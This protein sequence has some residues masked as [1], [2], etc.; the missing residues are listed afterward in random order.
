MERRQFK[1][2]DTR[3]TIIEYAK[4]LEEKIIAREEGKFNPAVVKEV[5]RKKEV[6]EKSEKILKREILSQEILDEH[7]AL[8]EKIEDMKNEI[9][10][11]ADIDINVNTL[12]ALIEANN[13]EVAQAQAAKEEIIAEKTAELAA[14]EEEI[15]TK[16]AEWEEED[17]Q[18]KADLQV[19]RDRE[20]ADHKYILDRDRKKENDEWEDTKNAREKAIDLRELAVLERE[21]NCNAIEETNEALQN[22][23]ALTASKIAEIEKTA[24]ED[25]EKAANKTLAIREAAMKKEVE[26]DK[27]MVDAELINTKG[28]LAKAEAALAAKDAELKEA[29]AKMN[30]LATKSVQAGQTVYVNKDNK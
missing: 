14:L 21:V 8:E 6:K 18:Y 20:A 1:T 23:L 27:K 15:K 7:K 12:A 2:K 25:A 26:F 28:A 22:E 9:K 17:K 11:I 29:Y 5:E 4:E 19:K 13:I 3:A 16:K 24:K 10:I 30:E